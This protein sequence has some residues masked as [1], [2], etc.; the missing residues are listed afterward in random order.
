MMHYISFQMVS[1]TASYRNPDFQNFHKSYLLPPPTTIIGMVGAGIG[2][3]PVASQQFF[4][5]NEV[6]VSIN[7]KSTGKANDLWKYND[8]KNGSVII[9]KIF[10]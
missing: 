2:L 7:G 9:R 5:D 10:F 8:F 4:I 1:V 3:S 6:Y